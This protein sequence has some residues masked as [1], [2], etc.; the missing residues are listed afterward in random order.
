M[1]DETWYKDKLTKDYPEVKLWTKTTYEDLYKLS[2]KSGNIYRMAE[3]ASFGMLSIFNLDREV[4]WESES[5]ILS[6]EGIKA[7]EITS[8]FYIVL[9]FNGDLFAVSKS[10]S[11]LIDTEVNDIS[12]NS[13][14]KKNEWYLITDISRK[15]EHESAIFD[16][17]KELIVKEE[18]PFISVSYLEA[19]IC[20]ITKNKLYCLKWSHKENGVIRVIR[21][22]VTL[23]I[24]NSKKMIASRFF[25]ILDMNGNIIEYNP[26]DNLIKSD[27]Y[28]SEN[29]MDKIIDIYPWIGILNNK[30]VIEFTS[31][32]YEEFDVPF[33]SIKD[34]ALSM[35]YL[36]VLMNGEIHK[37][38]L[39]CKKWAKKLSCKNVKSLQGWVNSRFV[40]I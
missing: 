6:I 11:F 33:K 24:P 25:H 19:Y 38:D 5:S 12:Y 26:V 23:E 20:A 16:I 36:Y 17:N 1:Y 8:N 35:D 37:F 10:T 22:L 2:L 32:K 34:T 3:E 21:E 28:N 39:N 4:D 7:A 15:Y 27:I 40:V 29:N 30:K 18:D 13:Y 14:I 9:K 31:P